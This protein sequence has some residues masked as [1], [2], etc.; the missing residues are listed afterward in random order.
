M[1][2]PPSSI[3][4]L[5]SVINNSKAHYS[6]QEESDEGRI[7]SLVTNMEFVIIKSF[8]MYMG[9]TNGARRGSKY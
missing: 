9:Q 4:L 7:I 6:F 5:A 2:H 3:L 8:G 1:P